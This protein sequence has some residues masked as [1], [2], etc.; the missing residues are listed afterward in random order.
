[1]T[2]HVW[3]VLDFHRHRHQRDTIY[4]QPPPGTRLS[5]PDGGERVSGAVR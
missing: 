5:E 1:M 2:N 4:S 3:A